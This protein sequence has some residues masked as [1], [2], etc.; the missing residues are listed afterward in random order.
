MEN[1]EIIEKLEAV[2]N[3]L[4]GSIKAY[5]DYKHCEDC[6]ELWDSEFHISDQ[7]VNIR[8]D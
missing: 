3:I 6:G 7:C 4:E 8:E 2:E 1:K 5:K